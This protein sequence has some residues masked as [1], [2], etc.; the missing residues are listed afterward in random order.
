MSRLS[1]WIMI[2][3]LGL[4]GCG[5]DKEKTPTAQSEG[6]QSATDSKVPVADA[7]DGTKAGQG[8][9]ENMA[10]NHTTTSNPPGD[11]A[12]PGTPGAEG[13]DRPED[14]A[15]LDMPLE[16]RDSL[17]GNWVLTLT[18]QGHNLPLLLVHLQ[19]MEP[20]KVEARLIETTEL[21]MEPELGK[22]ELKDGLLSLP[23]KFE[24]G[25]ANFQGQLVDG[26]VRGNL[27]LDGQGSVPARLHGTSADSV[28]SVEQKEA[29]G[30]DQLIE[31]LGSEDRVEALSSFVEK[32]PFSP[33]SLIAG[34]QLLSLGRDAEAIDAE[35]FAR[36]REDY[37]KLSA[38]WGPRMKAEAE[39]S[40]ERTTMLRDAISGEGE[41]SEKAVARL[42][43]LQ[44]ESPFDPVI[45]W[46][47][48]TAA[49]KAGNTDQAIEQYGMLTALPMMQR[50]LMQE[51]G[52]ETPLPAEKLSELWEKKHGNTDDLD[53][54][55]NKAFAQGLHT[56]VEGEEPV[57]PRAADEG[58]RIALVELFTGAQ[59]PPC[60]AADLATGALE[61]L[62]QQSEAIVVRYHQHIPGPDPLT[63]ADTEA[64]LFYYE[65]QGTPT[66]RVNGR[67]FEGSAGGFLAQ[68]PG[69]LEQLQEQ[70][71]PILTSRTEVKLNL[72]A[73]LSDGTVKI[74]ASAT[75]LPEDSERLRL[76]LILAE[77]SISFRAGNGIRQ[78]EMVVRQMPGGAEGIKP[79]D[80]KLQTE[81][82][83][84]VDELREE[85]KAYLTKFEEEFGAD[86]PV[87]PLDLNRLTVVALVQ[88]HVTKEVL[89]STAYSLAPP[90]GDEQPATESPA[91]EKPAPAK[92]EAEKPAADKPAAEEKPAEKKPEGDKPAA[93]DKPEA[94]KKPETAD[95]K[96]AADEN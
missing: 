28:A 16:K 94:E 55:L 63:T 87:K 50:M 1:V 24:Q 26:L 35:A 90:A 13:S 23:F 14:A 12:D 19:T 57:P 49:E 78:H 48:A 54:Y 33:L 36:V 3:C 27:S 76:R 80:G 84:N 60:V 38:T 88:D 52:P 82:T 34:E 64:R 2:L 43:E 77:Q 30:L 32:F 25:E 67:E 65:A 53:A 95:D 51:L 4:A 83:V 70:I 37:L 96:P 73:S 62:Y 56:L 11:K 59:C 81:Q 7:E 31:A 6:G 10:G 8:A 74:S 61:H 45:V 71:T 91:A 93:D 18:Q 68:A 58:N 85:L 69:V 42:K 20:G 21:L 89:Q 72:Q 66:I 15:A 40:A 5:G 22:A 39:E 86:F 46:A 41:A 17:T 75:G 79:A 29:E 47:L 92:P 9:T 44:K